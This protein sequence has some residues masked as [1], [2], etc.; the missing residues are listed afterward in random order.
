MPLVFQEIFVR[1]LA[2]KSKANLNRKYETELEAIK[3]SP[4]KILGGLSLGLL[5]AF[6]CSVGNE[7]HK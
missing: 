7:C 1:A 5:M 4:L 6:H 3:T 2:R